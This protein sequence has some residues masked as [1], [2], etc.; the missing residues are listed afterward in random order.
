MRDRDPVTSITLRAISSSVISLGLPR[1][2]GPVWL[3]SRSAAMPR[4]MSST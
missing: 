1:F 3:E 2:M 4:T